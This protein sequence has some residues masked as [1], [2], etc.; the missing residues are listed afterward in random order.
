MGLSLVAFCAHTP[1]G[2]MPAK[3]GI[4]SLSQLF[5]FGDS[6]SDNGN[7]KSVSQ[8]A[9][10]FTFPPAPYYDGRYSNGPV[11]VEYLW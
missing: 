1:L 2:M 10:G 8:N 3:A 5:S 9:L 4:S 6:L 7:S 11:A